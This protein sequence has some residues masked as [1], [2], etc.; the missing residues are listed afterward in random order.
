MI[1]AGF[2]GSHDENNPEGLAPG[3]SHA[4]CDC[5]HSLL[6]HS[7]PASLGKAGVYCQLHCCC[8]MWRAVIVLSSSIIPLAV[9]SAAAC[10]SLNHL[11][12]IKVSQP[13]AQFAMHAREAES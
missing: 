13:P 12:L 3:M 2:Y 7:S 11:D 8:S 4:A 6:Q 9:Q 1:E 5:S 10:N